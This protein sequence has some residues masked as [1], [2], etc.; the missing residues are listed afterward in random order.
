MRKL[1]F[2]EKALTKLAQLV[3]ED[4][5]IFYGK[6][7]GILGETI[8][9]IV[10]NTAMTGYQEILTDPSYS[11]Q[12]ILFTCP[13][14]GNIGTNE[15][16]EESIK[17]YAKGII[18]R[19]ISPIDSNFRSTKNT[20]QY[21]QEKNIIAITNIDTRKLTRILRKKGS[22]YGCIQSGDNHNIKHTLKKIHD[23]IEKKKKNIL[24]PIGVKKITEWNIKKKKKIKE[25]FHVI[26]YDFGVKNNILKI[27]KK[28]GCKITL[29][30]FNTSIKIILSLN[31]T[32]IL[33]SNGPGDPRSYIIAIKNIKKLLH[34]NIP[35]FGI[36]LGHQ[37]LALS[38]G[39][40]II[41]MKFGHH[42]SNH[43]V[44]NVNT[45]KVF[46]TSQNHNF[47]IDPNTIPKNMLITH[48]SLFDY[49]IQGITVKNHPSFS[50]QGHPES[51][52]GTH[53][54]Q[55]L[56]DIFISNMKINTGT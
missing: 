40:K 28:K 11:K 4:G 12:I 23:Y 19:T 39:S 38:L 43:P 7:I 27:L 32:G 54:I 1:T 41:K 9:E 17:I 56:F 46:I 21:I 13:H 37:I 44:Q 10:F 45:K 8:G 34:Y 48:I 47:T 14:I 20:L 24:S 52:P 50:F 3:L 22:Q 49:T 42:G 2:E 26:V 31:P 6:N 18:T 36:C 15:T 53:D 35:I 30:P 25:I 55:I 33:L 16:D 29:V 51:S 5:T